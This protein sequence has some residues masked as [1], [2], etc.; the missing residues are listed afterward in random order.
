M[1][2]LMLKLKTSKYQK[3]YLNRMFFITYKIY[4]I[5]VKYASKQLRLLKRN[6]EYKKLLKEYKYFKSKTLS[7]EEKELFKLVKSDLNDLIKSYNLT[8]AG[9]YKFIKIQQHLHKNIITSL[10]AQALADN[11][12]TSAEKVLYS[13]GKSIHIKPFRH[14]NIISQ[15]NMTNGFVLTNDGIKIFDQKIKILYKN[16]DY[17][18]ASLNSKCKYLELKRIEFKNGYEYYIVFVLEDEAPKKLKPGKLE[19]G[20][21]LG[22]STV[23]AVNKKYCTFEE[24]APKCKEYDL[25]I[26]QLQKLIDI[27]IR[28][29]NLDLY[30]E[31]GTVKKNSKGKFEYSKHCKYLKRKLRVLY[32]KKKDYTKCLHNKILNDLIKQTNK[33]KVEDMDFKAL[34]KRSK[35]TER[36]DKVS[37]VNGKE[38][39]KY[40]RK[41][42]FGKSI[43]DRSPGL[44]KKRLEQK[45]KQ[46]DLEIE[47]FKSKNF[48]F[49]QY[50][51]D[52]D[53]YVKLPLSARKKVVNNHIVQRDLYSAYL[54]SNVID[55]KINR[56]KCKRNFNT[57]LINQDK[58]IARRKTADLKNQNFGF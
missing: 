51:H 33:F 26:Q 27:S 7:K 12:L 4:V 6:K 19:T 10:Q 50:N 13:N 49:S 15:K 8:Q 18:I 43:T 20:I 52:S 2:T 57:F 39:C 14:F 34:A 42:R 28:A 56:N 25:K 31:D 36:S 16:T 38:V 17:E 48:K 23:A 46:Y 5:T 22:V 29:T 21:D 32:R 3:I 11:I 58:E 24:L 53:T 55:N 44:F 54:I 1:H 45:C 40:K 41:K 30:N 47:F 9:L 37:I 35:N